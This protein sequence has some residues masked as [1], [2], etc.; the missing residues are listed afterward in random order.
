MLPAVF[1]QFAMYLYL[2]ANS[3][4]YNLHYSKVWADLNEF[5]RNAFTFVTLVKEKNYLRMF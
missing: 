1:I 5:W 3:T 4:L 2:D